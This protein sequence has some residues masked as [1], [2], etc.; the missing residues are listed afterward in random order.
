LAVVVVVLAIVVVVVGNVVVVVRLGTVVVVV[1]VLAVVVV[2]FALAM[3]EEDIWFTVVWDGAA[4]VTPLGS[5]ASVTRR[6]C[7]NL[8]EPGFVVIVG[9]TWESEVQ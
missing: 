7:A 5:K 3:I 8:I 6:Y 1:A 2:V 9:F 4:G